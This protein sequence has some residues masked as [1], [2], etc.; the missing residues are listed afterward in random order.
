VK[1]PLYIGI[2]DVGLPE[3][4]RAVAALEPFRVSPVKGE[5]DDVPL[6]DAA[7]WVTGL[8]TAKR[9]GRADWFRVWESHSTSKMVS[10]YPK[11]PRVNVQLPDA[12]SS[13]DEGVRWIERLPFEVCSVGDLFEDEWLKMDVETFGF[14]S[15]HYSHGWACA[16]RGRGH[17]RLVSRRWIEFGPWRVIRRPDDLT[18]VQFHDLEVD[19]ETAYQQARPGHERMGISR[20]GGYLQVPYLFTQDVEGLYVA[21]TQTLEVIVPPGGIVEQ[22]R[23]RDACALRYMHRVAPPAEGRV[24][25]VAYVFVD[26]V[27]A[28]SHLHELWLRELEVWLVDGDGKRRLDLA[29]A[30]P[31][32]RPPWVDSLRSTGDV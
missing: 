8:L 3:T 28:R 31:P 21:E 12:F 15:S 20:S 27:D 26:D 25:H 7:N 4:L 23:M 19:A 1:H 30:P 18:I 29:Y 5:V 14:S 2:G 6:T 16:F 10:V 9:D 32:T 13:V 24:D 17:N 11:S 22:A